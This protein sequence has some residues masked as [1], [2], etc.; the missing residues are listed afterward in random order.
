MKKLKKKNIITLLA[1]VT[2]IASI[3]GIWAYF[4][5]IQPVTNRFV[6]AGS[7]LSITEKFDPTDKWL[8]GEK[9]E[10][11]VI[12][13]NTGN[14]D[15]LMRFRVEMK[16]LDAEGTEQDRIQNGKALF[17]LGW[18]R[19]VKEE[20]GTFYPSGFTPRSDGEN[21]YYYYNKLLTGKTSTEPV[22]EYVKFADWAGNEYQGWTAEVNII[23][24]MIQTADNPSEYEDSSKWVWAVPAVS[25]ENVTWQ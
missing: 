20:D 3:S 17:E 7:G 21:T 1:A 14:L 24:E 10:K 8:P 22:L 5:L 4:S 6:T 11:Q 18:N 16:V 19:P 2:A 13:D 12:F 9:K 23:C 25:G 15:M